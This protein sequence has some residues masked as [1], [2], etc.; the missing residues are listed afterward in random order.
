MANMVAMDTHL[1]LLL[2]L[3]HMVGVDDLEAPINKD[4]QQEEIRSFGSGFLPWMW[5]IPGLLA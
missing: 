2:L 1:I 5:T 3:L 4:R